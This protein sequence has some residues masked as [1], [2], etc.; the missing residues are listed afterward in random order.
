[1]QTLEDLLALRWTEHP[2]NPLIRPPFPSPII[3]D[4]TFCPPA[5]SPD[6]R[7]HLFAHSLLGIHHFTSPDGVRWIR[8]RGVVARSALRPFLFREDRTYHLFYERTRLFLPFVPWSSHIEV[9][10]SEDLQRWSAP[11]VLLRPCLPWH[12]RGRSRAVGNPCL[13]HH[14]DHH[15]L[16]YSA[17]LVRLPDCGFDEP[18][19][20][21]VA[22]G[23][24]PLGP[25][26]PLPDPI[27]SPD[28]ADPFANLGAGA[29]KVLRA[30]DG[31]LGL[32]NGIYRDDAGRTRSAVR[33]LTS[34][35]GLRFTVRSAPFLVPGAGWKRS[36]VYAVDAHHVDG[37][38]YL[39]FNARDDWH[40]TRGHEAIGL[41]VGRFDA[42]GS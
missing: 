41:V 39:Y 3:A 22:E 34:T 35:D 40:W 6:G 18:R 25:F 32:Q 11:H 24:T 30:V 13:L 33:M 4:P 21:G 5:E 27:L 26:T 1:M 8:H 12:V 20:V 36:H 7:W 10:T 2:G 15:R 42:G 37:A 28:S 19:H 38:T 17:G 29:L 23:P 14:E 9:R 31:F 16:Y